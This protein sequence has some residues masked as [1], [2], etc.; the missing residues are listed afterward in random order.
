MELVCPAGNLPA[1][2]A[3]VDN[4]A[5]AVYI[6]FRDDTN[7][8]HF[9]GLNFAPNKMVEGIRYARGKGRAGVHCA[10]HL[11]APGWLLASS[12]RL[13]A[14]LSWVS[15]PSSQL[16]SVCSIMRAALIPSSTCICRC[17]ARPPTTRRCASTMSSSA[18]AAPCC[19]GCS[20]SARSSMSSTKARSRSRSSPSAASA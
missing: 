16:T 19:R 8:R 20:R 2:K 10:Q 11:S 7:A 5:N 12:R 13:I 15:M 17:R 6:G 18:S 1:L 14:P 9:A 4:G 3:A